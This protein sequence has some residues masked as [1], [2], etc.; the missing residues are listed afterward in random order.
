VD[1]VDA[2]DSSFYLASGKSV[3]TKAMPNTP[4]VR[5]S[6]NKKTVARE[7]AVW[8]SRVHPQHHFHTLFDSL[9]GVCFYSKDAKGRFM[10]VSR[11][12]LQH[13]RRKD[14]RELL[15]LTDFDVV[16]YQMASGYVKDDELLLTGQSICVERVELWFDKQGAPD[17][18][19]VTKVPLRDVQGRICGTAGVVRRAAE[20]EM[21]LPI[22]Q[23][24]AKAVEIIRKGYAGPLVLRDV[25]RACGLSVRHFQRRF[26]QAFGFSPQEFLMKTRVTAAMRLLEETN[27]S[28]V[29]VA[30]QC[31]FV[32]GSSF[33]EQFRGRVGQ[34]PK[35][36]QAHRKGVK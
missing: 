31:G 19:F 24:V 21:Q 20:H 35:A 6:G 32:D 16:P 15:G 5:T 14:E 9:P 28:A 2:V 23:D 30:R 3:T 11:G 27:L 7:R 36:F 25:A 18:F 4:R 26:Q 13:H 34:S 12:F 10:L 8:L 33:A 1:V 29:E 22:I 17:W